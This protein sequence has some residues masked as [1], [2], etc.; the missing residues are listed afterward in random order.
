MPCYFLSFTISHS[1]VSLCSLFR[2]GGIFTCPVNVLCTVSLR[3]SRS[4][5][6]F[7]LAA[8][9]LFDV[10]LPDIL[11][12]PSAVLLPLVFV[13][14]PNSTPTISWLPVSQHVRSEFFFSLTTFRMAQ[15]IYAH[16]AS[17]QLTCQAWGYANKDTLEFCNTTARRECG[18]T[19]LC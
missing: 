1:L 17:E 10:A 13:C 4:L 2:C 19:S 15:R 12:W 3:F 8:P 16:R 14:S 11:S 7:F 6:T 5:L 18:L 9:S